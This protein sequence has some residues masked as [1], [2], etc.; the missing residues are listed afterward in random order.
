MALAVV[1]TWKSLIRAKYYLCCM[2]G[3]NHRERYNNEEKTKRRMIGPDASH[4]TQ[5]RAWR[6]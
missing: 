1:L 2:Q 5:R 4:A 3:L 6:Y